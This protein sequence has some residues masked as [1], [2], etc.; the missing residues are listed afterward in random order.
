ME[1]R[2]GRAVLE[3]PVITLTPAEAARELRISTRTLRKLRA[4]GQ[5]AYIRVTPR[6]IEYAVDDIAAFRSARRREEPPCAAA[7]SSPRRSIR[8]GRTGQ[9][10]PFTARTG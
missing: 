5:I 2:M 9:I 6:R 7:P 4:E 1:Q 3:P 10:L 8:R